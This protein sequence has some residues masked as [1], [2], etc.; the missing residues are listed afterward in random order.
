MIN[1]Y[2]MCQIL[3]AQELGTNKPVPLSKISPELAQVAVTSG[4]QD[5]NQKDDKVVGANPEDSVAVG[6]L[7][8]MQKEVV[9]AKALGMMIGF[10]LNGKPNLDDMEAIVSS[11]NYIMDG[12]HRW[13][14]ATL[15]NPNRSVKVAR[16]DLPANQLVTA[17]NIWTKAKGRGGNPG[18][19][20][21]TQF[22]SSISSI[23]D[24]AVAKGIPG[25]FPISADQVKQALS[26]IEGA[27]GDA[28]MGAQIVKKNA[29][30]LPTQ[31][32]PQ[33]PERV[34][35]P[36]VK[37]KAEINDVIK[38]LMSGDIDWNAPL[39]SK[40]QVAKGTGVNVVGA[41]RDSSGRIVSAQNS[42]Q[43]NV[44]TNVGKSLPGT[45][46]TI[47]GNFGQAAKPNPIQNQQRQVASVQHD[48]PTINEW[49]VLSGI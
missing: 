5:G 40:T 10:L 18:K 6:S 31:K 41:Q 27:N 21:V 39:S 46:Q 14:A 43:Q 19:G 44:G 17:L 25:E 26:K 22:A 13:A 37:N 42:T 47:A 1:F 23:L 4:N 11:D 24:E 32:H 38:R 36:V 12:H 49:L 29:T 9:P 16:V 34:D 48:D 45:T 28:N 35:M 20:D 33:A 15:I 7:K 30:R 3:E 8:P 2:E